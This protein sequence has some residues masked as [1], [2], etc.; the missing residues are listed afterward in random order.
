MTRYGQFGSATKVTTIDPL[1]R[2]AV[3]Q[4]NCFLVDHVDRQPDDRR[5]PVAHHRGH[6]DQPG[7]PGD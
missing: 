1:L 3:Q 6:P 5:T 4:S 7:Q 2:M